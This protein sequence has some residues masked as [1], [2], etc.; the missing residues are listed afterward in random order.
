[1]K[2]EENQIYNLDC[3]DGLLYMKDQNIKVNT[4]ITSPP[5]WALRQ[6]IIEKKPKWKDNWEGQL[7][8]EQDFNPYIKHLCNIFDLTKDILRDDGSLWVNIGDTYSTQGGQNRNTNKDY[9]HYNSIKIKNRMMGI[10]LV[11]KTSLPSKC[12]C[13][14]PER[15]A[16]EMLNRNWILR[17]VIIW[18]KPNCLPQSARDR[19]TNN[20]EYLYFFTK[21]GKYYFNQQ[22]ES[23][24]KKMPYYNDL[25][26]VQKKKLNNPRKNWKLTK[27]EQKEITK[28]NSKYEN[29]NSQK[30]QGF[31][32]NQSIKKERILSKKIASDLFPGEIKK[33]K[34]F[35]NYV[36][37]HGLNK[38]NKRVMRTVWKI[39]TKNHSQEHFAIFPEELIETPIK[40]T[41]P[42]FICPKCNISLKTKNHS[43]NIKLKKGIV[44]DIFSG[45]GTTLKKAS[46]L[47]R[48]YIGF[49]ISKKYFEIAKK[50]LSIF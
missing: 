48:N 9:S 4:I 50:N 42:K 29:E 16:I 26:E 49:E 23:S 40:A 12:L 46:Q 10:P 5:Y 30:T 34:S 25:S 2:I 24:N 47:K 19:F 39:K 27:I 31:I 17:N 43:C 15:F 1:M 41:C 45:I 32:R 6:Y 22:F 33:Q 35:I 13:M 36:H 11:K 44:L 8:L 38:I 14:I 7:G 18:H 3:R 20:Y 21:K 37:D 28:Y